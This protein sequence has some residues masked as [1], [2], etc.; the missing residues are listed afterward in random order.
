MPYLYHRSGGR[1]PCAENLLAMFVGGGV[2]V[3]RPG[4]RRLLPENVWRVSLMSLGM[5]FY[6]EANGMNATANSAAIRRTCTFR[7]IRI[8]YRP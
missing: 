2:R 5:L 4:I 1:L 8:R 7:H 6:V 3:E